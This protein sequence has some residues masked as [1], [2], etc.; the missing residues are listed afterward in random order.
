MNEARK[1]LRRLA[2]YLAIPSAWRDISNWPAVAPHT[3]ADPTDRARLVA[4]TK[5]A[6]AF[7]K[8]EPF[9]QVKKLAGVSEAQFF[10]LMERAL[11]AQAG[12][13]Q[14]CGTRAFVR[15]LVQEP[16]ERK[17]PA[18]KTSKYGGYS[19]LFKKLRKDR[20]QI[21]ERMTEFLNGKDRPNT[22]TPHLMQVKFVEVC[23]ADGLT[24]A[25][26]PLNTNSKGAGPL[27]DW[28]VNVYQFE[29]RRRHIEKQH[30]PS[31]AVA[32]QY[33]L[34]DGTSRTPPM[35][36]TVWVIDEI[37]VDLEAVIEL[38]MARWDVE[39]VKLSQ[40]QVLRC[41]SIGNVTCN[42]AWHLC[43]RQQ[44]SGADIIRLFRNAVLGQPPVD[45]VEPSMQYE[46]GAGFPQ[47]VF[48]Q[49]RF[50]VPVLIYLDNSLAHL[51]NALQTLLQRLFGGRVVLGIPGRPKGRPDIESSFAHFV[52]A[53]IH[54]LPGTTGTGPQDPLRERAKIPAG[55]SV[56]I[57]LLEQAI[58]VYF[59]NQNVL[60]SAGAGYLDS[61]TRLARLV[62]AN[63]IKCNYLPEIRR[64]PHNFCEPKLVTVL[65]DLS[66]SRGN[67]VNFKGRRYASP[68][69][70]V[71]PALAGKELFAMVDYDDLRTLELVDQ[72]FA[73]FNVVTCEGPWANV[74]HDQRM[75]DIVAKAR[76]HARYRAR[77]GDSALFGALRNLAGRAKDESQ[78]ALEYAY[79]MR[80]LKRHLPPEAIQDQVLAVSSGDDFL[81][82]EAVVVPERLKLPGPLRLDNSPLPQDEA[83]PN[84]TPLQPAAPSAPSTTSAPAVRRFVVPRRI[85]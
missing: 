45:C 53:L 47:N 51:F 29:N 2:F 37:K 12:T 60:E 35:P 75:L 68:W 18:G 65:C 55:K 33:E 16:R 23:K 1:E 34:G 80:Y 77:P 5:A 54:Q 13:D 3:V 84:L 74:P 79:V 62:L 27:H 43:L 50:A 21:F 71:Q 22:V 48:E 36:Y 73:T 28:Y 4:L 46:E 11:G 81:D 14:I 70:K 7:L 82:V 32:L 31:A 67:F 38:P 56:Q 69:M 76:A 41:R 25:D 42:I 40:F 66:D 83:A 17:A 20:P 58:D 49:L 61:F 57:G 15:N 39:Y 9:R 26:Y 44:A 30:G 78:A 85:A 52:R 8:Q 64:K 24:E 6:T 63:K 72:S 10:H 59:A 19:G